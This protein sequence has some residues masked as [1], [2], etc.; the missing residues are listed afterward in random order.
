MALRSRHPLSSSP[1]LRCPL[2]SSSLLS[3]FHHVHS[4]T[5]TTDILVLATHLYSSPFKMERS[6]QALKDLC[7]GSGPPATPATTGIATND[8][9]PNEPPR[10]VASDTDNAEILENDSALERLPAEIRLHILSFMDLH[11]LR[12]LTRASPVF[13]QQYL[14]DRNSLLITALQTTLGRL[15]F[16][17]YFAQKAMASQD[18]S[19]KHLN[20][21]KRTW[22]VQLRDSS[23]FRLAGTISEA[24][25]VNMVSFYFGTVAPIAWH[26]MDRRLNDLVR[27]LRQEGW[28][29][30][31]RPEF[32]VIEWRRCV[33]AVYEFQL[34]FCSWEHNCEPKSA[35]EMLLGPDARVETFLRYSNHR[36]DPWGSEEL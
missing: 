24:E 5:P 31:S 22:L 28:E 27:R 9:C 34:D 1:L 25:A 21:L 14:L 30:A 20:G 15:S 36:P 19:Y 23:S 26:F 32:S 7:G 3:Y 12:C 6:A 18:R 16:N 13:H 8:A 4:T 2:L 35:R 29:L 11:R 17:A 10:V 33:R